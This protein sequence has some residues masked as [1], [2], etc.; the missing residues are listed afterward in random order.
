MQTYNVTCPHC[1]AE[2]TG[3]S[4]IQAC[5]V[6][7]MRAFAVCPTCMEPVR[8]YDYWQRPGLLP[9]LPP[10]HPARRK[11]T[12]EVDEDHRGA[13]ATFRE[14]GHIVI[15]FADGRTVQWRA[16]TARRPG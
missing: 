16:C 4:H 10:D 7:C 12:F 2:T 9:P 8:L 1:A 14:T 3:G 13:Y 5:C 6:V 15:L 11:I